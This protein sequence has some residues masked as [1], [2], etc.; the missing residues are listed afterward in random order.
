MLKGILSISGQPGLFKMIA[1]AKN[2]II[3]ESLITGN[4]LPVSTTIKISSL[5]DIAVFAQDG[6]IP[7]K[8][9]FKRI[10]D[11][12][13]GGKAAN[14]KDSDL[15]IKRY[16]ETI[17]PDYDKNKVY[18]SDIRKVLNWYNLLHEK[19]LLQFEEVEEQVSAEAD[20]KDGSG[21]DERQ[22]NLSE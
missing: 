12:E 5:E 20:K 8:E 21:E 10:Y 3:V 1:E 15:L 19:E 22:E 7:L 6:E 11:H 18:V 13:E 17:L 16:F 14:P 4:R 2:R 9:I